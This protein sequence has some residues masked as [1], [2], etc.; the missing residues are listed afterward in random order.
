[1]EHEAEGARPR[2]RPKKTWTETVEKDHQVRKL[3]REDTTDRNRWRKH[4][5]DE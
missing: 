2:D 3:N 1:M 5:R 4:I